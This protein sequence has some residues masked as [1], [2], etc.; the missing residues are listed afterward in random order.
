MEML[1]SQPCPLV[2]GMSEEEK[3]E[4]DV[5]R[6]SA[7]KYRDE[8]DRLGKMMADMSAENLRIRSTFVRPDTS[9]DYNYQ[10]RKMNNYR[11]HSPTG[12]NKHHHHQTDSQI[13][14]S[15]L[16]DRDHLM[17]KNEHYS[18]INIE[19]QEVRKCMAFL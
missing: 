13:L 6:A 11:Q 3:E 5:A 17:A 1:Q 9:D 14:K 8:N 12:T 2:H 10:Q 4:L 19:L 18:K 7:A 15:I 16:S